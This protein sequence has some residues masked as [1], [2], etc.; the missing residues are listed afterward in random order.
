MICQ[1][2]ITINLFEVRG[3]SEKLK[4]ILKCTTGPFDWHD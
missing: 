4:V 1:E 3:T 2:D